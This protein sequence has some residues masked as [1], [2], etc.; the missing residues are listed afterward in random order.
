MVIIIITERSRNLNEFKST[1]K[2]CIQLKRKQENGD[3][4]RSE[5][6]LLYYLTVK[7]GKR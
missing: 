4:H 2:E 6:F 3:L 1:K 5:T 7:D